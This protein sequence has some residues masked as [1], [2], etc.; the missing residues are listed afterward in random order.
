MTK[1]I[2]DEGKSVPDDRA[3]DVEVIECLLADSDLRIRVAAMI[4][5]QMAEVPSFWRRIGPLLASVNSALVMLLAFLIPYMESVLLTPA[6]RRS[7]AIHYLIPHL[8]KRN[9]DVIRS[10]WSS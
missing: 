5:E 7:R 10:S 3:L 9:G 4:R 2:R 8:A 1:H 6:F